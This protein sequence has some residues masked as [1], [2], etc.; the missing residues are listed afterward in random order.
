MNYVKKLFCFYTQILPCFLLISWRFIELRI[1]TEGMSNDHNR[2][3]NASRWRQRENEMR[4]ACAFRSLSSPTAP[5]VYFRP[6]IIQAVRPVSVFFFTLNHCALGLCF[7]PHSQP[8]C[9]VPVFRFS[10]LLQKFERNCWKSKIL[11]RILILMYRYVCVIKHNS[12]W[13]SKI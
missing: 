13:N 7:C 6:T 8:L 2:P 9:P 11:S 5:R 10:S 3:T 4:R 12:A 1:Y